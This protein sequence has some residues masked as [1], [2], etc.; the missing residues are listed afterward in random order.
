MSKKGLKGIGKVF[1]FSVQQYFKSKATY[2]MLIVMLLG[3]TGSVLL[4]GL[5][6]DRGM[7]MGSDAANVYVRNI[8]TYVPDLKQMPEYADY[9]QIDGELDELMEQ[10]DGEPNSVL[11]DITYSDE[12]ACWMVNGYSGKNSKVT[13]SEVASLAGIC[14]DLVEQD[15]YLEL[16][17]EPEQLNAAFAPVSVTVYSAEEYREPED[18]GAESRYMVGFAYAVAV[19][20]LI[21]LSSSY[22]VK[23]ITEEKN[24]RIV[25]QL[26]IS[27]QP[28]AL[29]A[30]KILAAM[31]LVIAGAF[32]AGL[33]L[34][35][36]K[37]ILILLGREESAMLS[38]LGTVLS[39]LDFGS[40][41]IVIVSLLLGY[42][43]FAIL[44]GLSGAACSAVTESDN[45]SGMV[46]VL[47]VICYV[48]GM[49]TASLK[50]GSIMTILS[51]VPFLS[52]F[53]AP[54][55]YFNGLISFRVLVIGWVLQAVVTVLLAKTCAGVYGALLMYRGSRLKL[56]QILNMGKEAKRT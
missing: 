12:A 20:M 24:T 33:G 10:L 45:A 7:E 36:S 29:V 14:A 15:R 49:G 31:V 4:A 13:Q 39:S 50:A 52:T 6:M 3:T 8:G 46:M 47:S 34:G 26:M 18:S 27:I 41:L 42:F 19:Y 9:V 17:A 53:I 5:S 23:A 40:F 48:T 54:A 1:R 21:T 51:A 22:I 38:S 28:L 35:M 56:K 55:R 43:S 2:I 44:S 32:C 16:G 25:E 30:G 37:Y 11:L